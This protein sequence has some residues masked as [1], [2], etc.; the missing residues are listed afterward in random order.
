MSQQDFHSLPRVEQQQTVERAITSLNDVL[1]LCS[2]EI[3]TF[4]EMLAFS[5]KTSEFYQKATVAVAAFD[6][7][8]N[9]V[10][11]YWDPGCE[12]PTISE[13][14]YLVAYNEMQERVV[15]LRNLTTYISSVFEE[16]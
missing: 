4:R 2:P 11:H 7:I 13:Q 16:L 6:R 10:E 12:S 3:E 8:N 15:D 14:N 9:L 1:M 5:E